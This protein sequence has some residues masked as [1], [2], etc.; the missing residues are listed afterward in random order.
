M[1]GALLW[2]RAEGALAILTRDWQPMVGWA[3]LIV[4]FAP[5][6]SLRPIL[7]VPGQ[8]LRSTTRFICPDLV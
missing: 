8:V 5:D 3:A 2:Q 1:S 7:A 6:L 4:F